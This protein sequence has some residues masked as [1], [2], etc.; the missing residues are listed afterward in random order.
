[1]V[2]DLTFDLARSI[3]P[4]TEDFAPRR[5]WRPEILV[6]LAVIQQQ[7]DLLRDVPKG[8]PATQQRLGRLLEEFIAAHKSQPALY[9]YGVCQG[10][11]HAGTFVGRSLQPYCVLTSLPARSVT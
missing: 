1:M 11:R 5:E 7:R 6:D 3:D 4:T 2:D 8:F 9:N 10:E